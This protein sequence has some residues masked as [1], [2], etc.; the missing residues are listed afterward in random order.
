MKKLVNEQGNNM[1]H[2]AA[3]NGN[4]KMIENLA[5]NGISINFQ[6]NDGNT[7]LHYAVNSGIS[8]CVDILIQFGADET[9]ENNLGKTPWELKEI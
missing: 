3:S 4:F 2:I 8:R 5:L 7:P 6:N 1:I 9:I